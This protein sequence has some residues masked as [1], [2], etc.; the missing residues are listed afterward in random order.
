MN[1]SWNEVGADLLLGRKIVRVRYL[2]DEEAGAW[3]WYSRPIAMLLDNGIWIYPSRDDEG[4]DGGAL[5]TSDEKTPVLPVL[6]IGFE[7]MEV[8]NA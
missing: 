6:H 3:D 7:D 4:N 1:K 5:F 2:T 8:S